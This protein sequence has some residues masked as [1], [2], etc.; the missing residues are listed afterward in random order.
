M[1]RSSGR[2]RCSAVSS[3]SA[4]FWLA[5]GV[6]ADDGVTKM[7]GNGTRICGATGVRSA[8]AQWAAWRRSRRR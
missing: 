5:L 1:G 6:V 3:V 7:F 2:A 8:S 4:L